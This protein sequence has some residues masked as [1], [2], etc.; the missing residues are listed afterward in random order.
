MDADRVVREFCAA[1]S[2]TDVETIMD[3]FTD[4][5][6]YHNIPMTPCN[7]KEEIRTF[8][9]TF[10]GGMASAVEFDI[11]HQL[12]DG[13]VGLNERVD[14]IVMADNSGALPVCGIF[15]LTADGKIS[16]W[17]DYFDMGQ[18]ADS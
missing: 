11:K 13:L 8:L 10:L 5:A 7:G 3:A 15:E 12:V 18:F 2:R 6:I 1:W 9:D 17:R 4:D 14:T 16:G